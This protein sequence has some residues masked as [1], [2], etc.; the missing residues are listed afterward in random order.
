MSEIEVTYEGGYPRSE[1]IVTGEVVEEG[2]GVVFVGEDGLHYEVFESS[3]CRLLRCAT[4]REGL[5]SKRGR[6]K[7]EVVRVER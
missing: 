3:G 5:G 2:D 6:T 4:S 7:G 1:S